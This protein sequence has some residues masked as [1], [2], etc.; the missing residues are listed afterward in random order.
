MEISFAKNRPNPPQILLEDHCLK[1]VNH[2]KLLGV[3]IQ[4][5]L[6]WDSHIA[7]TMKRAIQKLNNYAALTNES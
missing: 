5:D 1:A 7:D 2:V 3:T 4:N 6:K